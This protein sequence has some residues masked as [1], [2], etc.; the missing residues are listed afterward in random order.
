MNK[1]LLWMTIR[2]KFLITLNLIGKKKLKFMISK[3]NNLFKIFKLK[4][5]NKIIYKVMIY[6]MNL[7]RKK[8]NIT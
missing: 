7:A 5:I 1:I 6:F 8:F 3:N 2:H 4:M